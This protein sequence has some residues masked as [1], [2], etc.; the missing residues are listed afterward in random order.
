[1][2]TPSYQNDRREGLDV[3]MT[4]MIDV[5]FLLLIFFVAT[6]SFQMVEH[7]LPSSL[8]ALPGSG[9]QSHV[10]AHASPRGTQFVQESRVPAVIRGNWRCVRTVAG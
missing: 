9:V 2:R 10:L 7:V 4:P 3:K 6:A 8:Q 5:V 1:M